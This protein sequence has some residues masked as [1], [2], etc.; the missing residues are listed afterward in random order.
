MR[1]WLKGKAGEGMFPNERVVLVKD[2]AGRPYSVV[3][4][5]ASVR[6]DAEG[7]LVEVRVIQ[8]SGDRVLVGLLGDVYGPSSVLT[9]SKGELRPA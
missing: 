6:S 5:N 9:V 8:E 2:D 3:V 4:D 7:D 1:V